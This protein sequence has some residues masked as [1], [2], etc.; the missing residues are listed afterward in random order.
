MN[1]I[2]FYHNGCP[3]CKILENKLKDKNVDYIESTNMEELIKLGFTTVP[4]L[5]I[6]EEFLNFSSAIKYINN[7]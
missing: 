6:D 7:L 2:I 4:A 1:N 5:K 3:K